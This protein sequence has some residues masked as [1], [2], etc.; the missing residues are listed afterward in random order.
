MPENIGLPMIN[1]SCTNKDGIEQVIQMIET[2][3][4]K[5]IGD[6]DENALYIGKRHNQ[7]INLCL[8]EM[9]QFQE[10]ELRGIGYE[11]ISSYL[12]SARQYIDE[13]IGFKTNENM[14]DK[15]FGQFCIG[16]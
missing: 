12:T 10:S 8:K 14:L 11:I 5:L 6:S 9:N 2:H 3:I 16:K 13:M 4:K 15:L 7:L 1:V